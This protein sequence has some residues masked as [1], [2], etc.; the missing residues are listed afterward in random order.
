MDLDLGWIRPA[1]GKA[2]PAVTALKMSMSSLHFIR[3]Q[4]ELR[5]SDGKGR[6][7]ME[8]LAVPEV[9]LVMRLAGKIASSLI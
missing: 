2:P 1:S 5:F 8:E 6:T 7:A 9:L 4:Q 3:G